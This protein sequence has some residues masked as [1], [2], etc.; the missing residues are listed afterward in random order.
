M[1]L[2]MPGFL[3]EMPIYIDV[4]D[5]KDFKSIGFISGGNNNHLQGEIS[6]HLR[7]SAYGEIFYKV[8]T[9]RHYIM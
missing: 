2:M 3:P 4:I 1:S 7:A 6:S 9:S 5:W 8:L